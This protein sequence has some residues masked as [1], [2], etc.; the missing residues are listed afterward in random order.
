MSRYIL[1]GFLIF[2]LTLILLIILI[3]STSDFDPSNPLYNGL[4]IFVNMYNATILSIRDLSRVNSNNSIVFIIGPTINFSLAD[5][6][7]LREYIERGGVVV[8]ADDFGSGN[9]LLESMNVSV[10]F[11]KRL[12]EDP[13]YNFKSSKLP[14]ANV[15]INNQTYNLYL[16]YATVINASSRDS[17]CIGYSSVYSYLDS[18][19]NNIKDPDEPWGPFCIVYRLILREGSMVLISDPSIFI[20]SMI[21][22][23]DNSNFIKT[24]I[25]N[26]FVYVISDF[27]V[28]DLYSSTRSSLL[29]LLGLIFISSLRYPVLILIILASIVYIHRS[30]VLREKID[31]SARINSLVREIIL[32]HPDWDERV[33]R[34]IVSEVIRYRL[35]NE[36]SI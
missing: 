16:N 4:E 29:S 20:N 15:R 18:N 28:R 23:G 17:N 12:L 5:A 7:I 25:E 19:L 27:W 6:S 3:P 22:L 10:R 1:L 21:S 34:E 13:L 14:I 32:R 9:T 8:L 26:R 2:L 11:D 36:R 33:V 35:Q 30:C 31:L 24:L